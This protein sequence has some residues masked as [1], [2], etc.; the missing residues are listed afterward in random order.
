MRLSAEELLDQFL[1][2][3]HA[4]LTADQNDF[5]DLAGSDAGIGHCFLAGLDGALDE[6]LYQLLQ[7]GASEL[8]DQVLR[9]GS[10]GGNKRQIDLGFESGRKLD[11]GFFRCVF[12]ALQG[13][14]IAL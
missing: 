11:L 4:R 9:A 13:H 1:N 14:F 6:I 10:V 3:R 5:L 7:L 2:A 8:A 12:Q